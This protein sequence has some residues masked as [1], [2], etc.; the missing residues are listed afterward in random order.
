[1]LL[2]A[3]V[4]AVHV[5]GVSHWTKGLPTLPLNAVQLGTVAVLGWIASLAIE[6]PMAAPSP[7][8]VTALAYLALVCTVVPFS[9]M[10]KAQPFTTPTRA[11]LIYSMEAVFAALF[12]WVWIGE[13]PSASVWIGGGLMLA[14]VLL[15]EAGGG[16]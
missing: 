15:M 10:L 2:C 9:L 14:A 4:Y 8:T 13:V 7:S 3:F 1:V 6:G 11:S 5:V 16:Q 12:S